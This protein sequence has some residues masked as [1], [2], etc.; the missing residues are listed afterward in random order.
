MKCNNLKKNQNHK[1]IKI[2]SGMKYKNK[3]K[4]QYQK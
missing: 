2:T 1:K 4:E 3:V